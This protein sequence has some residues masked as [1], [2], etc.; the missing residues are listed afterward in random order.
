AVAATGA[1][2]QGRPLL[3]GEFLG[4]GNTAER[5]RLHVARVAAV[6]RHPVDGDAGAAELRPAEAAVPASAT[7]LVVLIHHALADE[8][9]IGAGA[10]GGRS[11]ERRVGK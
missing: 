2:G 11:E 3:E 4:Q 5:G 6:T 10:D 1:T 8:R 9:G 7:A